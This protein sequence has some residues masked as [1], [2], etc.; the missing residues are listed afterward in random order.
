MLMNKE[1]SPLSTQLKKLY[2][3]NIILKFLINVILLNKKG[4]VSED[5]RTGPISLQYTH[6]SKRY[7]QIHV[8]T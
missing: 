8:V 2:F 1:L 6:C 3:L 7:E 5:I 4:V